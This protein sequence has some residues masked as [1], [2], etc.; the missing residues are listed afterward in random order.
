[1][2]PG[3]SLL[4]L[5]G[6]ILIILSFFTPAIGQSTSEDFHKETREAWDAFK[7]YL[8]DQKQKAVEHGRELLEKADA[9]IDKLQ[10]KAAHA[11][12]ETKSRYNEEVKKLKQK[13]AKAAEKLDDLGNATADGWEATKEGFVEAYRDLYDAYR[14]AVEK[15]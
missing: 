5:T 1:M 12:G 13:R 4:T 8:S 2:N 14:E 9:E 11:S 10:D 6:V 3:I 7:A 15:F